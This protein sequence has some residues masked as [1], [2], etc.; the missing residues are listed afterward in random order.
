MGIIHERTKFDEHAE[1]MVDERDK[2]AIRDENRNITLDVDSMEMWTPDELL[3]FG[4]WLVKQAKRI[5]A[6]YD[7]NGKPIQEES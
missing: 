5:R 6:E 4:V 3:K 1:L 7:E 2:D